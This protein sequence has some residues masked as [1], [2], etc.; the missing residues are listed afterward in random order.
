M[1]ISI[2]LLSVGLAA[3][4]TGVRSVGYMRAHVIHR[5]THL[6]KGLIADGAGEDLASSVRFSILAVAPGQ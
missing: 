2:A 1:S 3:D 5:V 6:A 4:V